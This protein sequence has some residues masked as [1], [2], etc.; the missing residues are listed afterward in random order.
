MSKGLKVLLGSVCFLFSSNIVGQGYFIDTL[1]LDFY[2]ATNNSEKYIITCIYGEY[3][4]VME[5]GLNVANHGTIKIPMMDSVEDYGILVIE[6]KKRYLWFL[7]RKSKN[8]LFFNEGQNRCV[9]YAT[10]CGKDL[11]DNYWENEVPSSL[12]YWYPQMESDKRVYDLIEKRGEGRYI[13]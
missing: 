8:I 2:G 11:F 1:R 9:F 12:L 7:W 5:S 4:F 10:Y 13:N 3:E 6:S